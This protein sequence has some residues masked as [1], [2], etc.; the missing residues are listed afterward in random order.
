[1]NRG[2]F[3]HKNNM[4]HSYNITGMTCLGCREQVESAIRNV[5]GVKDAWVDLEEQKAEI[6]MEEH[7]QI[8]EFQQ[9]LKKIPGNY[10]IKA[11][12]PMVHTYSVSGMTCNGCRSHVEEILNKVDGV[13]EAKVDLEKAEAEIR[14]KK[15]IPLKKFQK[16]LEDDGGKYGIHPPGPVTKKFSVSGM[17]CN[18]CRSHVEEILNK[19]EGV[20]EAKVN[21]EKAEAE[22]KM[23]KH[24]PLKKFQ[25]TFEEDGGNYQIHQH[26]EEVKTEKKA[27]KGDGT[28]VY[29]CPCTL[30]TSEA[31]DAI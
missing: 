10:G 13:K 26:G 7:I 8:E 3:K 4:K 17:T 30:Y 11:P 21:L 9:A 29:Y 6:E 5:E 20:E 19:V 16:A 22:I 23:K 25:K 27:P 31:A 24:I 18:G 14:M 1:M 28:G 2:F 15:H 12:G